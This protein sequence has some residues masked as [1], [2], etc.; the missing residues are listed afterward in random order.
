MANNDKN[1]KPVVYAVTHG[2]VD[3]ANLI[4]GVLKRDVRKVGDKIFENELEPKFRE[5]LERDGIIR[6]TAAPVTANTVHLHVGDHFIEVAEAVNLI[7]ATGDGKFKFG[8]R[9]FNDREALRNG[10][11]VVELKAALLSHVNGKDKTI[12]ELLARVGNK[13]DAN[14]A[15]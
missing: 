1:K 6:N 12:E 11:T 14:D 4:D 7:T 2:T 5:Q 13:S 8:E 9:V 10:V 3:V 15:K